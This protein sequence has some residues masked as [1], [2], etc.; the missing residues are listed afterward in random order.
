MARVLIA[1]CGY[2]GGELGRRLAE[3]GDLVWGLKRRPEDLADGVA[4][5][6]CDL[7]RPE[8]LSELPANIDAVVFA[9]GSDVSS[10][11]AYSA[12]Y[13]TGLGN[14]LAAL[15]R[16]DQH[17]SRVLVVTSTA[18]YA[19]HDG[20][21][22]D[23]VSPA[24]PSSFQG[25]AML[26]SEQIA[27]ASSFDTAVVRFGGIFGPGR[28][29]VIEQLR[30][31]ALKIPAGTSYTNRIHRDDCAGVLE[32]LL[33]APNVD[34]IYVGSDCEPATRREVVDWISDRL[35]VERAPED[36]AAAASLNKRCSSRRLLASGYRFKDPTY[37]EGYGA[38]IDTH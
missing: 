18:V 16:Q 19:Q 21:H 12:I 9:A 1:G 33:D 4:P 15:Q 20:E 28:T 27:L 26:A 2:V 36:P 17:P 29:R 23:E 3:R 10:P 13:V 8:T 5:L 35:G 38:L 14:L 32:H 31:R 25:R 7:T 37:R 11:D 6:A 30:R 34:T 22:V 24:E